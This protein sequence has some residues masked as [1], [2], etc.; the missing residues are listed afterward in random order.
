MP[1]PDLG[2][3]LVPVWSVSVLQRGRVAEA[4]LARLTAQGN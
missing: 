4:A 2:G 1:K 3:A